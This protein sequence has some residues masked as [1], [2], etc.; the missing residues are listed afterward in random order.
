MKLQTM[1]AQ[2]KKKN[3]CVYM[4][5]VWKILINCH[6]PW[7][8]AGSGDLVLIFSSDFILEEHLVN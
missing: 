5:L 8:D 1:Q 6:Q 4:A 3:L 2:K 7:T